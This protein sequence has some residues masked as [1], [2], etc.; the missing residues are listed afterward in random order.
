MGHSAIVSI[1]SRSG[2]VRAILLFDSNALQHPNLLDQRQ[3][4]ERQRYCETRVRRNWDWWCKTW[5]RELMVHTCLQEPYWRLDWFCGVVGLQNVADL[6]RLSVQS[7][8][9]TWMCSMPIVMDRYVQSEGVRKRKS[10]KYFGQICR[11]GVVV[12]V[13]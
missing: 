1:V 11:R 9:Y 2:G 4:R 3:W 10:P 7:R 5:V 13:R 8:R 12:N 6:N